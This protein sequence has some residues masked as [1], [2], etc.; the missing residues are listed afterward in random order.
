MPILVLVALVPLV[1]SLGSA[2]ATPTELFLSEYIEGSSNNK[3]LEIYNG[4]SAPVDL[5]AAGYNVQ[6]FFNGN[7][8]AGLTI[9]LN[10]T[11]APGDVFVLAHSS[12]N[13]E[14]LAQA[15][16]TNGAGW[17]NGDDAVVLRKGLMVLDV[18]G[19]IGFDPGIEWGTGL[20]S[21]QDNTLR[22]KATIQ[23]GDAN[24]SDVFDP[25]AQWDG[26]ATNDAS[27]LGSHTIIEGDAAP[28]VS[29]TDPAG[30]ASDV[31]LDADV[32]VTFSEP[33][34]VA[35]AWFSISCTTS[36]AH[37][38]AS[39]GGP[40][41]F[42]LDPDTDFAS[43][44]SCTVAVTAAQVTDVDTDDPPDTMAADFSWSF[45]TLGPPTRIHEIQGAAHISP[46]VGERASRVPGVVTAKS[47]N[48][49]YFQDPAPDGDPATSEGLF[50]FGSSAAAGVA[51]GDAVE[52]SGN[53]AEFRPGG[54]TG[55][56]LTT[57]ELTSPSVTVLSN[58]N[59]LPAATVV[60]TGGRVP[61]SEVIDNDS[62][63]SV[64][65]SGVFDPSE[66]GID[67][68]E[69]L[70]GMRAQVNDAVA[71]GPSNRFGEIPVVGDNGAN[72]GPRTPR[73]GIIISPDDFNPERILLDDTLSHGAVVNVGDRFP[74]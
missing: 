21:T 6:M 57:T 36:G 45:A 52:V 13:A 68:Y 10:G 1:F 47:S 69:S 66:D 73:G 3:A 30:G 50:V 59:P 71:V 63:G 60:G 65:T 40:Q 74:G 33:V 25:A 9:A 70:E 35:G 55:A 5:T 22:R 48:G 24:G 18:I 28:A 29:A 11:V 16:Q 39:S 12:A 54:S 43:D 15:D 64:E 27:G 58:G 53:V 20:A 49:F 56:N 32:N 34:N 26:F 67:F 2:R 19:Q 42:T 72:A 8:A 44:E 46:L 31:P 37:T 51:V 61:P 4:T 38:A 23:A 62:S 7:P 17:F 14:I 41:T